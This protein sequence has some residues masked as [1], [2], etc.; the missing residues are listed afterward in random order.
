VVERFDFVAGPVVA[1][2][3]ETKCSFFFE[4]GHSSLAPSP[5][6]D[7]AAVSEWP[8]APVNRLRSTEFT[9]HARLP[10]SRALPGVRRFQQRGL[11]LGMC[12]RS[13]ASRVSLSAL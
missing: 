6:S 13:A 11:L 1:R 5:V 3:I 7:D 8:A 12:R 10:V 2:R 4:C 9:S